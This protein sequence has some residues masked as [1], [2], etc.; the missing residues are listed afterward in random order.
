MILEI[1]LGILLAIAVLL[2][3][4]FIFII[5][6]FFYY[7]Y[8]QDKQ[9]EREVENYHS[10]VN[11]IRSS[12]SKEE[13]DLL[14]ESDLDNFGEIIDWIDSEYRI[15]NEINL[16]FNAKK[17]KDL[18]NYTFRYIKESEVKKLKERLN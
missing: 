7:S 15:K 8:K 14:N 3:I 13:L 5:I 17:L 2:A 16:F 11:S 18:N 4:A 12:L 10:K 9:Y 1:A 6:Y